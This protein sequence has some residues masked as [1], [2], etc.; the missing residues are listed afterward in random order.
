MKSRRRSI[1]S[2]ALATTVAMMGA[3]FLT[4]G[5][6][7]AGEN[8]AFDGRDSAAAD[9]RGEAKGKGNGH[10][11]GGDNRHVAHD[12]PGPLTEKQRAQRLEAL[13]RLASGER[14]MTRN[15]TKVMKLGKNEYVEMEQVKTDKIFTILIEFGD[16]IDPRYGGDPGPLHNQIAEPDRKKDNSTLW[17]E[18]FDREHFEEVYFGDGE[19]SLKTYYETQSSGKYSVDGMVSDWVKVDYNEARYGTNACGDFVC[20]TVWDAVRDGVNKWVEG[21]K[22]AGSTDEEI[23]ERLAEYDV[24]DRYDHDGDGDFNEPDGYIDHFQFVHAGEDE[25]AGGGAQG[26]DAIWAHRWYAY[27]TDYGRTGPDFNKA[28]GTEIGD[29]GFWVGDYT[30]QPENG[31]LG[32]FAHEYG[33]DL[34]LPDL[35][36][37]S[38]GE[39]STGFWTL[40]S[41][42]SWLNKGKDALGDSAGEMTAWDKLQLGWLDYE[43]AK[44]ATKSQHKLGPAAAPGKNAQALIVELPEKDV[45]TTVVKPAAGERQWWSGS[46]DDLRNSLTRTVDLTGAS[47][48]SLDLKGWWDIEAGYDYLYTQVS[49]DGG[50]NWTALDGTRNGEPLGRDASGTPALDGTSGG[51]ADLSYPLD[52]YAGQEIQL[53][54][55]YR[56]DGGLAKMGFTADEIT[57]TADGR[58]LLTDGAEGDDNGWT[59]DGFS[60]IGESFTKSYPQF[61]IVEYR[62]YAGY[63]KTLKTGPY[64]FGHLNTRP[65]WVERYPYQTGMLV[66]LWDTSQRDNNTRVH[67]GEGLVLPVDAH[68]KPEKWSDGTLMRN[69]IQ[70]Y[71]STF[72]WYPT[73]GMTLHK[74]GQATRITSKPGSPV[75]DDRK[76]TYWYETNP[77]ASVKV[78]DTNTRISIVSQP[79]NGK[80]ITVQV[81][82]SSVR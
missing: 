49:T 41:S 20:N 7:H 46:G 17:K 48:A 73:P 13:E 19:D 75:F 26:E 6:A 61:Y 23:A 79:L 10:G 70:S 45:T 43:T 37:T 25:S 42:G 71:D 24:W 81:G 8:T 16:K 14:P 69:R 21:Q 35:Y 47:T 60:R 78:P 52:A 76:G 32:V 62:Q 29:T 66:W 28:G 40:M 36:D 5:T 51:W 63:D 74:D 12:L 15:G 4:A 67:P 34:G 59:A 54:F 3:T 38:G 33:H 56:T 9:H 44:A 2:A 82:P 22:A 11:K 30:V 64:N 1:R 39:N 68:A 53:R 58:T 27:G 55:H 50:R 18:N 57:I 80:F 65:D 77:T 31:G 72:S